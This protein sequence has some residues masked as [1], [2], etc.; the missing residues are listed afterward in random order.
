MINNNV[1]GNLSHFRIDYSIVSL[2]VDL[3]NNE[4]PYSLQSKNNIFIQVVL[5]VF[6]VDSYP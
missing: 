1:S 3:N 6:S 5:I 4:S 2:I